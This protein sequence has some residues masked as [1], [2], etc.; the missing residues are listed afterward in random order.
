MNA[1]AFAWPSSVG[2]LKAPWAIPALL[3]LVSFLALAWIPILNDSAYADL[4]GWYTDHLHHSFATWVFLKRGLRVYTDQ[5]GSISAGT[6]W[7]FPTEDWR[8]MPMAYPPGMFGFFLPLSLAGRF[9]PMSMH[10]FAVLSVLYIL[11]FTHLAL[12]AVYSAL[13]TLPSGSRA[14]VAVFAW[15]VF[16]HLGLEGFYDGVFLGCGAWAGVRLQANNPSSALR[17]LALAVVLH[18]RAVV[19][20]PLIAFALLRVYQQKPRAAW[21]WES[22]LGLGA[23]CSLCLISF[24]KMYPATAGFR[25]THAVVLFD[26]TARAALVFGA[27]ALAICVAV[28]AADLWV[29]ATVVV[30][31]LLA[32]V[33]RQAY[34]WHAAVLLVPALLVGT[35]RKPRQ[36]SVAR[37]ILLGWACCLMP[38]VWRDPVTQIFPELARFLTVG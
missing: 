38:L 19:F 20:L 8:N 23:A 34:W 30:C 12:F 10:Q 35:A 37:A 31:L 18:F 21:T 27:S 13:R 15:M 11:A 32:C 3:C 24:V 5:F 6:G 7:P 22:F 29:A 14:A 9:L 25:A 33:E 2:W 17:W 36:A 4:S 26:G 28:V 1:S 16:A